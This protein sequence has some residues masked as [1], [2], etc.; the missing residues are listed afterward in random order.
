METF[1]LTELVLASVYWSTYPSGRSHPSAD[2]ASYPKLLIITH[3]FFFFFFSDERIKGLYA[4][5]ATKSQHRIGFWMEVTASIKA[6]ALFFC[7]LIVYRVFFCSP[8]FL[9]CSLEDNTGTDNSMNS[10]GWCRIENDCFQCLRGFFFFFS[11]LKISSL[12]ETC[13][14]DRRSLGLGPLSHHFHSSLLFRHDT[15][16]V[17]RQQTSRAY[18]EELKRKKKDFA[19]EFERDICSAPM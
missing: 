9:I 16:T 2:I 4:G 12:I 7:F 1:C 15:Q 5:K 11:F 14:I 10:K 17:V 6:S 8:C 18:I 13:C 19:T 3:D